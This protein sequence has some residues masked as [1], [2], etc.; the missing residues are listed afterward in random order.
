MQALSELYPRRTSDVDTHMTE[1]QTRLREIAIL[2]RI[3]PE[4]QF[5]RFEAQRRQ[6]GEGYHLSGDILNLTKRT[7]RAVYTAP[8][9]MVGFLREITRKYLRLIELDIPLD[10]AR[11]FEAE[12][13][14][15]ITE[16]EGFRCVLPTLFFGEAPEMLPS[17]TKL[18]VTPQ[19]WLAGLTEIPGEL[20]RTLVKLQTRHIVPPDKRAL[21][22][23][24][25]QVIC[26]KLEEFLDP[27]ETVYGRVINNSRR[28]GYGQTFRGMLGRFR[29][30]ML[31]HRQR[32]W[33]AIRDTPYVA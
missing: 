10:I 3:N 15:E 23:L 24:R 16:V 5:N 13:G 19:A 2:E 14:Q 8:E 9:T 6:I 31:N 25:Y 4:D 29:T 11:D 12:V 32:L 22:E 27:Y 30:V 26:E 7:I 21:F 18:R 28:L 33:E 17:P 20:S 1:F